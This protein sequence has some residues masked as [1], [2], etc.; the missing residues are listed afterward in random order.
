M[1]EIGRGLERDGIKTAAGCSHWAQSTI[2]T[3]LS[4]EKYMGDALLQKTYTV[5]FL[6]KKRIKNNGDIPQYYVENSHPAIISRDKF[7]MAQAELHRRSHLTT[8]GGKRQK[9]YS[10]KYALSNIVYCGHC[11]ENYRRVQWNNRGCK[12]V[13]WRCLSRLDKDAPDCPAR[14]VNDETLHRVIVRAVNRYIRQSADFMFMLEE[15]ISSIIVGD[16]DVKIAAIDKQLAELQQ[17]LVRAA[18]ADE[19]YEAK[20]AEIESLRESRE[21]LLIEAADKAEARKRMEEISEFIKSQPSRIMEYDEN[22]VRRLID[23]VIVY[24]EHIMVKFKTGAEIEIKE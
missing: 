23:R 1:L 2:R 19:A 12:S 22:L 16:T 17:E 9:T 10:G 3:I 6:T 5:D 13:V 14:T 7:M 4:N 20:A 21:A 15:S 24:D 8:E 11:G 18:N